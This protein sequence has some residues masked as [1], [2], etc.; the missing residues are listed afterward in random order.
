MRISNSYH[1]YYE[2]PVGRAVNDPLGFA[3]LMYQAG[4]RP[5]DDFKAL[6]NNVTK[7]M[8]RREDG[9]LLVDQRLMS[10]FTPEEQEYVIQQW[11]PRLVEKGG[12]RYGAVLVAQNV[13]AR[14]A[15]STI[16]AA[17]RDLSITYQ[18]FEQEAEAVNWLISQ[19]R[20]AISA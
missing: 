6:L 18:Y 9:C 3:R 12:Y 2:N 5:E 13:F 8:A 16:I 20:H 11:L 19:Q 17:V 4:S 14:L 10:P 15:T 7:L 1:I